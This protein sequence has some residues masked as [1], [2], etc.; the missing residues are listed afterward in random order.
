VLEAGNTQRMDEE[1]FYSIDL[2]TSETSQR[3]N[4]L[5]ESPTTI[6]E[7]LSEW[8]HCVFGR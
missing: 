4:G 1:S 5:E 7:I 2:E 3:T 6:D 8:V